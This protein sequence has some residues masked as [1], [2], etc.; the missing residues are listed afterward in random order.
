[1]GC[2]DLLFRF[3]DYFWRGDCNRRM[4]G[5]NNFELVGDDTKYLEECIYCIEIGMSWVGLLGMFIF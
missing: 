2:F 4:N 3:W 1:M 5:N